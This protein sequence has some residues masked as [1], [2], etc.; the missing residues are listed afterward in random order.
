MHFVLQTRESNCIAVGIKLI[1]KLEHHAQGIFRARKGLQMPGVL[2]KEV[3]AL[4]NLQTQIRDVAEL[5]YVGGDFEDFTGAQRRARVR[6][7]DT[8]VGLGCFWNRGWRGNCRRVVR[9]Y[10]RG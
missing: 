7:W 3:A 4:D 6:G 5:G 10:Q 2:S 1:V 9:R 8:M